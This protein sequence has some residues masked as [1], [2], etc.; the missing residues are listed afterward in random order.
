MDDGEEGKDGRRAIVKE[1]GNDF[2]KGR[3]RKLLE[4]LLRISC[5]AFCG[6]IKEQEREGG[7]LDT[8]QVDTLNL[9]FEPHSIFLIVVNIFL[10]GYLSH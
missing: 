7:S 8:C 3:E 5:K 2:Q 6:A 9:Y 10:T 4:S 1:E